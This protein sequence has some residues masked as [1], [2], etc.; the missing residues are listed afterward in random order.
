MSQDDSPG[1]ETH[2]D[3]FP[4]E[5]GVYDAHCHPTDIMASIAEIPQMKARKLTVMSTRGEDQDLV[6][7]IASKF[8]KEENSNNGGNEGRILPCFGWHPWFSYQILDDT[9]TPESTDEDDD[10][11]KKAHYK[12]VLTPSPKDDDTGN[13]FISSL[14]S[15]KPL[16]NLITQTRTRLSTHPTALIGEIG[17]D[18]AFRLPNPWTTKDFETRDNTVTPGSREGRKLSPY[19]VHLEHQKVVL[20][21]QLR[22][23]GEMGRAVSIHSV[24][25]HG[26]VFDVFKELWKGYER[27][28]ASRKERRRGSVAGAYEESDEDAAKA[29]QS[30]STSEEEE[31]KPSL[32]FP[33]RICMHSYSGPVEAVKQ[34]LHLANPSDV[35]FSFSN[36]INFSAPGAQKA[37]DVVKALP[38]DRVL[39]ESDLHTA[40]PVMDGLLEDVVRRICEIRGWGLEEGVRKLG[41]NWRRFVHG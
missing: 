41:D 23:A 22:L 36:V 10:D 33:P 38:D 15:P 17:L 4:W 20:R 27:R 19:R 3:P 25:A 18:R 21:A 28:V 34:F 9:T 16:S 29:S 2:N 30:K 11:L 40:G 7:N 24:Q 32:P 8:S 14:P 31:K 35:Y 13:H 12:K 26:A 39:V 6:F 5:L 37:I 1:K